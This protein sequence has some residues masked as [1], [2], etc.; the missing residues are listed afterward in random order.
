MYTSIYGFYHYFKDTIM[1]DNIF[2]TIS[3]KTQGL[4]TVDMFK[5]VCNGKMTIVEYPTT[6]NTPTITNIIV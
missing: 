1:N 3:R 6:L 4:K 5:V 2:I